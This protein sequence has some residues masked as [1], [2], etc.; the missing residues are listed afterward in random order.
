[1]QQC[2]T[3]RYR[4]LPLAH[5]H[6]TWCSIQ[7]CARYCHH[8]ALTGELV[9]LNSR[10]C[11]DIQVALKYFHHGCSKSK[12]KSQCTAQACTTTCEMNRANDNKDSKM[13]LPSPNS[14]PRLKILDLADKSL[15]SSSPSASWVTKRRLCYTTPAMPRQA[16]EAPLS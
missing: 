9:G 6:N 3:H 2:H 7:D 13:G 14:F 15:L 8:S 12:P 16:S 1:M 11:P 4:W 5:P 10:P